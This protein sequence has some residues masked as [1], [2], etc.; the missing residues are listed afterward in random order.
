MIIL[1]LILHSAVHIYDFHIF[2][3]P[4]HFLFYSFVY[5]FMISCR[6][7]YIFLQNIVSCYVHV[8]SVCTPCCMLLCDGNR[9]AKF[10]SGQTR[11]KRLFSFYTQCLQGCDQG[12][13]FSKKRKKKKETAV[14]IPGVEP[15]PPG[16]KPG[17]LTAR[18][19]GIWPAM[20]SNS[21]NLL[22]FCNCPIRNVS[23]EPF[24][25]PCPKSENV[26][27]SSC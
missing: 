1:H 20:F 14:P 26:D 18:P 9:C 2:K 6:F 7:I 17:I 24:R 25:W 10:G 4:I 23:H 27:S 21:L 22:V 5:F 3:T 16:W 15:G 8:A 13:F 19:Y 12:V 11:V